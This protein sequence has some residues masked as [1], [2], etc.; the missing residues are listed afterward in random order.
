MISAIDRLVVEMI[1]R[2]DR[3]SILIGSGDDQIELVV[4]PDQKKLKHDIA[5]AYQ[6]AVNNSTPEDRMKLSKNHR[7]EQSAGIL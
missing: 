5:I 2:T 7:E 1:K 6:N 4:K 3:L